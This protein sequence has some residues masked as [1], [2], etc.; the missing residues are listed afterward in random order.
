MPRSQKC[1]GG[2]GPETATTVRLGLDISGEDGLEPEKA[3]LTS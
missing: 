1:C 3:A 2:S